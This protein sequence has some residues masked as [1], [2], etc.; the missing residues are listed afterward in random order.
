MQR[1]R[2]T[3]RQARVG[4]GTGVL[5]ARLRAGPIVRWRRRGV[6]PIVTWALWLALA[7][8]ATQ[9]QTAAEDLLLPRAPLGAASPFGASAPL[10]AAAAQEGGPGATLRSPDSYGQN[11]RL[12]RTLAEIEGFNLVMTTF[13][14]A[15]FTEG[16]EGFKVS[17]ESI[18]ENLMAGFEWDDNT[19]SANN[20]RHPYQGGMY[21]GAARSNHYDFYQ[22]SAFS[23]AGA[24]LWEYTGEN[25]HP[26][27]NDWINTAVGGIAFGEALYR[28]STMVLDNTATK[29]RVWHEIGGFAVSPTRGV[30]RLLTGEA[31]EVHANPPDRI[32]EYLGGSFRFG[33]RTIG[34]ERLWERSTSKLFV[35]FD[36]SYGSP[37][38]DRPMK[39]FDHF[40]FGMQ[41]NFDNKPHGIGRI[42]ISGILGALTV[43]ESPKAKH[44]LAAYQHFEYLDNESYVYGGQSIGASY[45]T[46]FTGREGIETRALLNVNAILLG[47]T[48]SDHFNISGRQYDYGPGLGF[49]FEA[50]FAHKGRDILTLGHA[51]N[52]VHSVNGNEVE[53][54]TNFTHVKFLVPVRSFFGAG[55]E[56]LLYNSRRDYAHYPDV[57]QR[58]P[59]L[60]LYAS[61]GG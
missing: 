26:S 2:K 54:Y 12:L 25:H 45:L 9:A 37:F 60:R 18:H 51:S 17:L 23:F 57:N 47:A 15:F 27:V 29:G 59:E 21:Y 7:A 14:R 55:A 43:S 5:R 38:A 11:W 44:V 36:A 35:S 24:W 61:W 1:Q 22:S 16:A 6:A 8:P 10:W 41:L 46:R 34:D 20:F 39:P 32:P 42:E 40:D 56:F 48:K 19:F 4:D 58:S 53:S 49:E 3:A 28:L 30:N 33:S 13:G 31:F 50:V 52:L